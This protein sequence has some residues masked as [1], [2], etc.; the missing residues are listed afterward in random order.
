LPRKNK[1]RV[2]CRGCD[3]SKHRDS[4]RI[5]AGESVA[6]S[7]VDEGVLVDA[8]TGTDWDQCCLRRVRNQLPAAAL[9]LLAQDAR[10]ARELAEAQGDRNFFVPDKD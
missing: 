6:C 1:T 3:Y 2:L 4:A 7:L 9:K 8:P 10:A 5:K